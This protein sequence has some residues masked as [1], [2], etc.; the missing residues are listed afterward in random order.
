MRLYDALVRD[1]QRANT[2]LQPGGQTEQAHT[3]LLHAQEIVIEL[4]ASLDLGA[5]DLAHQLAALYQYMYGRLVQANVR[6]DSA[7]VDEVMTLI[8]PIREAWSEATRSV[9]TSST[10]PAR[11]L[12][13]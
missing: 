9:A 4:I 6:K 13:A 5:G 3:S 7:A 2:Q 8:R 12:T 11:R 1:L 10:E